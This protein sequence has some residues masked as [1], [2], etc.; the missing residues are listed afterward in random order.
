MEQ[1]SYG[2]MLESESFGGSQV[3]ILTAPLRSV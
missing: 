1:K 2:A 3:G